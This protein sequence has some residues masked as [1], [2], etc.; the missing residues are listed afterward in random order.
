MSPRTFLLTLPFSAHLHVGLEVVQADGT[1]L[2]ML[3]TLYKDNTG[4]HLKHLFVGAEGTLGM[5]RA[6]SLCF[7]YYASIN[8][9]EAHI[10]YQCLTPDIILHMWHGFSYSLSFV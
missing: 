9:H 6:V 8:S 2:D 10:M 7:P 4:Y 1:V 5:Y 3:R